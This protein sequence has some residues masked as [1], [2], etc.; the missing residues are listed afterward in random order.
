MNHSD[1]KNMSFLKGL[2]KLFSLRLL[3]IAYVA[4]TALVGLLAPQIA[5]DRTE[6][7]NR[8]LLEARA[9]APGS[10]VWVWEN[11]LGEGRDLLAI[12][13]EIRGETIWVQ[14]P[15]APLPETEISKQKLI[16]ALQENRIQQY[17]FLLG[18][19]PL[20]RDVLSRLMLGARVSLAVGLA[21][22]CISLAVGLLLGLPAGWYGGWTEKLIS[23]FTNFVWAIP[24]LLFAMVITLIIGQG[25]VPVFLAVGLTMWVDVARVVQGEVR[26]LK[27]LDYVQAAKALGFPWYRIW[28][29][30]L[31]P[32]LVSPLLVLA[33]SNFAAAILIESGLSF[34]GIGIQ[35]PTPTWGGMVEAHRMYLMAG[36]AYLALFPGMAIVLLV[37]AFTFAG[38][39]SA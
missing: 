29:R 38:R 21:A 32:S 33:A 17:H 18:T 2:K 1:P 12:F 8:Q 31:L 11:G 5:P 22:V 16:Q 3:G 39:K 13:W 25:R 9:L 15:S 14:R 6:D 19:D 36:K 37:L 7:A 30:H 27:N 10:R 20:G 23:G 34:M 35:P 24:T 28:F 4:L 26:R